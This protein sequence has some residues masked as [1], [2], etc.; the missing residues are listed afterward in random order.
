MDYQKLKKQLKNKE[1]NMMLHKL[2]IN[3]NNIKSS[4]INNIINKNNNNNHNIY[5]NKKSNNNQIIIIVTI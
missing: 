3:Y 2:Q 4:H 5:Y 1:I